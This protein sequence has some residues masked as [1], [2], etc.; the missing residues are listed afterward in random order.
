MAADGHSGRRAVH[1]LLTAPASVT[2]PGSGSDNT[3][4]LLAVDLS[5]DWVRDGNAYNDTGAA[6]AP[7]TRRTCSCA[8]SLQAGQDRR[9]ADF[10]AARASCD[11]TAR[12]RDA[13]VQEHDA[14][15]Q[16]RDEA[17]GSAAM[18]SRSS[19]I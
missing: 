19:V 11:A 10:S 14:A 7:M 1:R 17:G 13:A 15:L 3:L 6:G 18:H 5:P 9:A 4:F 12:E 2:G 8:R 16:L